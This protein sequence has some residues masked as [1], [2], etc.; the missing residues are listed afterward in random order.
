MEKVE[1]KDQV[2]STDF[3]AIRLL[4]ASPDAILGW[5]HGEVLKPETINY[6]TQKPERDGLFDERIFGPTKDWECY[7]GK[8]RKVRYKGVVCDKCGVEVTRS[9]VRRVRMGHIDLAVPVTHI[10]YVRGV[11]SVMGMIL[12]LPVSALEKVI[13]FASFIVTK[14]DEELKMQ[15]LEE[16][17]NQ[18]EENR[19]REMEL[20]DASG[21]LDLRVARMESAYKA[22]KSELESLAPRT[23]LSEAKFHDLSIN[24]GSIVKVGIGAEAVFELLKTIDIDQEIENLKLEAERAIGANKRKALKRLKIFTNMKKAEIKPDWLVLKRLPVLPPDLRPMVQLDGGRFAASDLNDLYRRVLNRNNRL[25]RLVNQGAPEVI[26]RNE[27]RM[28]QEAVDSLIDNSAKQGKVAQAT[29]NRRKLR[30]LSDMLRGKQGRFR[31]NLLGKRVDYS[32]RS[33]IVVG[34]NLKLNECGLPKVMALE[35]FKPFVIGRLIADGY[36]HNVKNATRLIE[37]GESFVWDILEQITDNHY[38]LLNRAPT[39][40]RL[41]IQAFKPKLIEGRAIQIH[42]LV[43]TAFNADFDGD[44]MAVH[45]PLSEQA[46]KEAGEIMLSSKNLLKPASGEPVVTPQKDIVLGCYF[47]SYIKEGLRGEGKVFNSFNEAYSYFN[48]GFIKIQAKIKVRQEGEMVETSVGRIILNRIFPEEL[49]F[50]NYL[51]DRKGVSALVARVFREYGVERTSQLVDDLKDVGFKY[52]GY[53]GITFSVDDIQVPDAKGEIITKAEKSLAQINQQYQRGLITNDERYAKTI[54]MWMDI[55]GR[56][57]KEMVKNFDKENDIY[58]IFSSG[59]RGSLTQI[60]QIAGMKGLVANPSGEIIELPIKSN[61]KEGLSVFEYFLSSHGSRK[62][63][64]DTALRTSEA[65]YLTRR[66]VDVSQ[67]TIIDEADCGTTNYMVFDKADLLARGEK[68]YDHI[69]TRVLGENAGKYKKGS[70]I[71]QEMANNLEQDE[72]IKS[73]SVRTLLTCASHRGVCQSCYGADLATGELAEIGSVVGIV[74]AQAIG[75]PGTQL[76]MRTFHT[77]GSA[78]EDI[79][80]GLPRVEELFEARIPKQPAVLAELGGKVK[81]YDLEQEKIIEIHSSDFQTYEV[82]LPEGYKPSVKDGDQVKAK[83]VVATAEDKKPLRTT[84][85]GVAKIKDNKIAIT[86]KKKLSVTYHLPQ[87]VSLL[88]ED[89]Q[90]VERG[91]QLTE[92]SLELSMSLKLRGLK[93]T[94]RYIIKEVQTI[95]ESQGQN[96]NDKHLEVIVRQMS[97]KVKIVDPGQSESLLQGQIINSS[98]VMTGNEKLETEKKKQAQTED[99]IIGISRIAIKTD[100]FLSAASFQETTSVLIDAAIQGKFDYL[101]GLK[102]NVIIG[103]L[104]PAGTAYRSVSELEND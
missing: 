16:L 92:G 31:Q 90:T 25:K 45:I 13:Y 53:S 83:D 5:S 51:F 101:K 81:I 36:V 65:G 33:V 68:L 97:S 95:Y 79:V 104:I 66:L 21:S 48:L 11:P 27:K 40:H 1:V 103:R 46:Q 71:N 41:G 76:T 84:L 10:W 78:G 17:K 64:A 59:A 43:C 8:Y 34:A 35:L 99:L 38:V 26:C 85:E 2:T 80:S 91:A 102:E 74:A 77:G 86:N 82:E 94:Q 50:Q 20:K 19:K 47:L 22:A 89:G 100:S 9:N 49:G 70:L 7:C 52:A 60:N 72:K 6:R 56:L 75:E 93:E 3:D 44:Q 32:G 4:I 24:Y 28:L 37:R 30:S 39:L 29:G 69:H 88:V 98:K 87:N 58:T 67:D 54:E 18:Y 23:I 57:E 14:V 12:D 15:A 55:Q 96:I 62:G 63:R 73:V 42:P 61:F